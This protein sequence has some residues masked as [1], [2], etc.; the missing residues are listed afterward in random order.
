MLLRESLF[1]LP[2]HAD[3]LALL[4]RIQAA[5]GATEAATTFSQA[6]AYTY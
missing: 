6:A 2:D 4:G 1:A 5:A 3:V